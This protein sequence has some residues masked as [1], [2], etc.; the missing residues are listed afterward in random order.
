[1][2]MYN[3]KSV[4]A[5]TQAHDQTRDPRSKKNENVHNFEV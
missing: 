4:H 1:M 3:M 2:M 5:V